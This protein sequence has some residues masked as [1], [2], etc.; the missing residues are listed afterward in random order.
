[1]NLNS[2]QLAEYV[3]DENAA[4]R[5]DIWRTLP[6]AERDALVARFQAAG[7]TC[8]PHDLCPPNDCRETYQGVRP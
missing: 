5:A 7:W 1:M 3:T 2:R 4:A 8:C 6:Y